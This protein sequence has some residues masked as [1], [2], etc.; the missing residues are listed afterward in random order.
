MP[1]LAGPGSVWSMLVRVSGAVAAPASAWP[2]GTAEHD[3][4]RHR[5]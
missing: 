5:E 4:G 1:W 2:D 3:G